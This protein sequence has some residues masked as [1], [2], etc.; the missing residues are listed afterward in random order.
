MEFL[1]SH[2]D[3]LRS[4]RPLV[5][6]ITNYVVMNTTANALLAVG[7]SP[8]MS[9]AL[10]EV[11]EMVGLSSALVVN[12]GTLSKKWVKAMELAMD[13]AHHLNK[14]VILDP[15]GA[16]A[17]SYRTKTAL[18]LL[19]RNHPTLIRGNASEIAALTDANAKTKGVD[20]S[21]DALD[22][23][24]A[25]KKLAVQFDATVVVSGQKDLVVDRSQ[26]W[27]IANGHSLMASITGMG[28]CASA[29]CAA[30]AAISSNPSEAAV[31]AMASM[32]V[33]GEKAAASA[34]GPGSF[35]AGFLDEL[36]RLDGESLKASARVREIAS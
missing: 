26:V 5:H 36:F 34:S 35:F 22:A 28:C 19:L 31:T 21:L 3:R 15:V 23:L 30:F 25:A 16:G 4:E 14:P 24:T 20:S 1:S 17:T 9:H 11:E 8:V 33:A 6:N 2:L 32:G 12:I 10:E 18:D 29:L 7:A 13:T 27:E